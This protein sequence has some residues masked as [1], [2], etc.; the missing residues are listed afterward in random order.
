MWHLFSSRRHVNLLQKKEKRKK[1]TL[2]RNS[3]FLLYHLSFTLYLSSAPTIPIVVVNLATIVFLVIVVICVVVCSEISETNER[4]CFL[5]ERGVWD[6]REASNKN[7]RSRCNSEQLRQQTMRAATLTALVCLRHD[8]YMCLCVCLC[9]AY[10]CW[11]RGFLCVFVFLNFQSF[12]SSFWPFSG[13]SWIVSQF[14]LHH[15]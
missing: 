8:V 9:M 5:D 14:S 4:V 12:F 13:K 15:R 6:G 3:V 1:K 7:R 11:H 2:K 10:F